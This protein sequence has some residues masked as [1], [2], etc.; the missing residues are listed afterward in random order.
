MKDRIG[1]VLKILLIVC[2]CLLIA[3]LSLRWMHFA[4]SFVFVT[5]EESSLNAITGWPLSMPESFRV[6]ID[7]SEQTLILPERKSLFGVCLGVYYSATSQGVPFDERLIFSR[8]GRAA[9]DLTAP[10]SLVVPGIDGEDVELVNNLARVVSGKLRVSSTRRDGTV[11]LEYGSRHITLKPGES[12]AELLVLEPG[13]PRAVSPDEWKEELET[14]FR[15][16][17]PATRLAIANRGLWP[18]SGVKAGM[19]DD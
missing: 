8:T 15:L 1:L 10:A 2:A 17:Y 11:E 19:G 7:A 9:L 18:K 5:V 4:D 3:A 16:G 13:G 6:F 12:W 14:C